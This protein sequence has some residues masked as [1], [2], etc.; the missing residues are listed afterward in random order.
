[1]MTVIQLPPGKRPAAKKPGKSKGKAKA[2]TVSQ[3]VDWEAIERD[4][5]E[6][7]FSLRE[8]SDIYGP[9]HETI[10]R[11]A[12]AEGW[13]KDLTKPIAH[14]TQ[15]LVLQAQVDE[16][17][18]REGVALKLVENG[19]GTSDAEQIAAAAGNNANVILQHQQ[20]VGQTRQLVQT[21]V[22]ELS[23]ATHHPDVLARLVDM[24]S[25]PDELDEDGK[26]GM[27]LDRRV[28]RSHLSAHLDLENRIKSVKN[29]AQAI[30][31]MQIAERRAHGMDKDE[32]GNPALEGIRRLSPVERTH[33]IQAIL[34]AAI[35]RRDAA[36]QITG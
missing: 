16:K 3:P 23:F 30:N 33:R 7:K 24:A 14:A 26:P 17:R 10:N 11:R 25:D 8:L 12:K 2:V 21:M 35:K 6:A 15:Q 4:F 31:T 19:I 29:L 34:D 32:G 9:S 1:M 22:S 20:D 28:L 18:R 27:S 13:T 36:K 5:R